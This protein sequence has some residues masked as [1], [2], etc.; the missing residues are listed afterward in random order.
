MIKVTSSYAQAI[1]AL[2]DLGAG[3]IDLATKRKESPM[4][5]AAG[6]RNSYKNRILAALTKAE[7][8]RLAPHLSPVTLESGKTLLH[9][10]EDIVYAYFLESGL[11]S[12][13]VAMADGSSV[14]TGVTGN[15]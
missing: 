2:A 13:V 9:P 3:S 10:G 6:S 4:A 11:A 15:E 7:I 1:G 14:E 12:V 5:A 8:T